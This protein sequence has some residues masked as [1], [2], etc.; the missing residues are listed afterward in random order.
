MSDA[1]PDPLR[2]ARPTP[3]GARDEPRRATY[4]EVDSETLIV[5][6]EDLV[7]GSDPS[8]VDHGSVE[9]G[10]DRPWSIGVHGWRGSWIVNGAASPIARLTIDPPARPGRWGCGSG[11]V[12]S[13][14]RWTT[15]LRS[16]S[17]SAFPRS[18]SP[19]AGE[20]QPGAGRG[21]RR[22]GPRRRRGARAR[23]R[24][25]RRTMSRSGRRPGRADCGS[26]ARHARA[27]W[28]RPA[29]TRRG[30]SSTTCQCT[31]L[32]TCPCRSTS[33]LRSAHGTRVAPAGGSGSA[34]RV[35]TGSTRRRSR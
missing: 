19:R 14:S 35:E 3:A 4:L 6:A 16:R 13:R 1:R 28:D 32:F 11:C 27:A 5:R 7:P 21:G 8:G 24:R 9:H 17:R 22:P 15:L 33:V 18:I 34:K 31:A 30:T 23:A 20:G 2:T 25:R 12:C 26:R 29:R 10:P